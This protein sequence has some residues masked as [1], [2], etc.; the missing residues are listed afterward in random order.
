MFTKLINLF[1]IIFLSLKTHF[2]DYRKHEQLND[3]IKP[4]RHW[5]KGDPQSQHITPLSSQSRSNPEPL[6]E[7]NQNN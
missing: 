7:D 2:S 3:L 4:I 1:K 6:S 5:L